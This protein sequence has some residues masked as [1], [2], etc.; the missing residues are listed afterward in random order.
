MLLRYSAT[1]ALAFAIDFAVTLSAATAVHYLVA[2]ALGFAVANLAQFLLA[3]GWVF[4][5]RYRWSGL[6]AAY[7]ATLTISAVGLAL[8]SAIVYAG[9]EWAGVGLAVSKAFA[10]GIV[11]VSNFALRL[12]TVYRGA[13][14]RALGRE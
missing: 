12:L 5:H 8:S 7:L 14:E 2:N 9:I 4:G 10:A 6:P 13:W 11:L 3:H 1:G